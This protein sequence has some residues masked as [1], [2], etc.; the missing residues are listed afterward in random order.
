MTAADIKTALEKLKAL[1]GTEYLSDEETQFIV[2]LGPVL[3][4]SEVDRVQA[5]YNRL[6]SLKV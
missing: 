4:Q 1:V 2:E 3:I 5:I 6:Y